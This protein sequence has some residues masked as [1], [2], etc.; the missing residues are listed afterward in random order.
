[1]RE[2]PGTSSGS[3]LAWLKLA[4]VS[5]IGDTVRA[6]LIKEFRTPDAVLAADKAA[7]SRV[8]GW[9]RDRLERFVAERDRLVPV[10]DPDTIEKKNVRMVTFADPEYPPLLREIPDSPLVL[11]VRGRLP[12]DPRPHIAIVGARN[13]TQLGF[14]IARDFGRELAAAGF[15]V[16]SGLALGV[17]TF[18]HLGALEGGGRTVA[19]LGSGPDITYPAANR[20][21]RERILAENGAL[22]SEYPP[23]TPARP[24][25]FPVRNRVIAGM[26]VA[27][28]VVEA[29]ARSGSLITARLAAEQDREV[30]AIPGNIRSA[31]AEGT[32]ALIKDGAQLVTSPHD[33]VEYYARLLPARETTA[34]AAERDAQELDLTPEETRLLSAIAG[35][36]VPLDRL[37]ADGRWTRDRLFSLLLTLEMRDFLVKLPGNMYHAKIKP[38]QGR[39]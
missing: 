37:L 6:G 9:T 14:D 4:A 38:P 23:G 11:F 32:L 18:A 5:W 8:K 25:H 39:S 24:W 15:V 17:D 10:C 2:S 13:G 19:V 12:V 29:T 7:L 16:V 28:V 22:V 27:T 36:P 20:K 21:I 1:M 31:L 3:C 30:F 34:S 33:L 35:E 26:C